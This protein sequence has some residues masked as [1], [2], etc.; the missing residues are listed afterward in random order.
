MEQTSNTFQKGLQKDTHPMVQGNDTLTNA[1]N[2]TLITMK[3]NE[4]VLQNDMGNRRVDEAYLPA[5]YE[6]VGIKEYGGII[7]I[8]SYNPITNKSQIGSFPSPQMKYGKY[9]EEI[10]SIIDLEIFKDGFI[11]TKS[12]FTSNVEFQKTFAILSPFVDKNKKNII[13]HTGD[14]FVIY[15]KIDNEKRIF[16]Q[17]NENLTPEKEHQL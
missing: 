6:P 14:K 4:V 16:S 15:G 17:E 11:D 2:A 10:N 1:L 13:L 5:G 3:G 12:G 8:A 9:G 7:Y